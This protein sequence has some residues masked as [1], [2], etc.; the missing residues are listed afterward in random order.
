MITLQKMLNLC[1]K[2]VSK[3]KNNSNTETRRALPSLQGPPFGLSL[4]CALLAITPAGM[5]QRLLLGLCHVK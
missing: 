4:T 1:C 3:C 5:R 2:N